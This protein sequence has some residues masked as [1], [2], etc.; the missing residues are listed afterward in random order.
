M[1]AAFGGSSCG[2]FALEQQPVALG[3]LVD[4]A[5]APKALLDVEHQAGVMQAQ[6]LP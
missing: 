5:Q 1:H 4:V 3:Q 2:G 6:V